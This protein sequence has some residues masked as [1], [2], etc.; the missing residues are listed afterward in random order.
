MMRLWLTLILGLLATASPTLAQQNWSNN[1]RTT[2]TGGHVMGNPSAPKRLIE[3]VSYTCSHCAEFESAGGATLKAD[4][5]A[6]GKMTVEVRSFLRDPVDLTAALLARC[7]P[8]S[9][10]FG[11]HRALMLNQSTWIAK[12]QSAPQ[13]E[14]DDWYS[15]P[16]LARFQK[17][18]TRAGFYP[19]M[20]QRGISKAAADKCLASKAARDRLT[21]M[22]EEAKTKYGVQGTP[23]FLLND[24]LLSGVHSWPSLR[25]KLD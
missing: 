8:P 13:S 9:K 21:A 10:F 19:M 18:A 22:T 25:P 12:I 14:Q 7:G 16:Y 5:V 2:S 6:N 20:A 23:S 11:N 1:V 24:N 4:Y 3:F 15:G 17:I